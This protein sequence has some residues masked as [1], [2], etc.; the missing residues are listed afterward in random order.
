[1]ND[2]Q[3]ENLILKYQHIYN[4]CI[5]KGSSDRAIAVFREVCIDIR[6]GELK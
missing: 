5:K 3:I 4:M 6:T 2:I 1:M